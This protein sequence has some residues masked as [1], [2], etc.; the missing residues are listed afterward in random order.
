MSRLLKSQRYFV[1]CSVFV[2]LF[3][4]V[5]LGLIGGCSDG[6]GQSNTQALTENDFAEDSALRADLEG[7][8]VTFLEAPNSQAPENDTGDVGIDLV[9]IT[10]RQTTAQTFCWEDDDVSAMHFMELIDSQGSVVL[11]VHVNGDCVTQVI[12]AGNYVM[13][14]HHDGR[15]GDALPI[16]LILNPEESEQSMKT[17]GLIGRFKL[18]ASNILKQI[19]RTVTKNARAQTVSENRSILLHAKRCSG[20]NLVRADLRGAP[21][22]DALLVF[23]DLTRADLSGANLFRAALD[24]ATLRSTI[25]SGAD[26]REATLSSAIMFGAHLDGADLREAILFGA[27]LGGADFRVADLRGADLQSANLEAADLR[28]ADLIG[29]LFGFATWCDGM[30]VCA[31]EESIGTCNGCAPVEE[32]CTGL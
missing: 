6:S 10:F 13:S 28:G 30:C 21:L 27:K 11:T 4:L 16:F 12:E 25:F 3:G 8:V 31:Q 9:P 32:V 19:D 2:L 24:N 15:I 23:A 1:K 17:D 18:V 26:M 14:I 22:S 7:V 5:S 29:A 20:C